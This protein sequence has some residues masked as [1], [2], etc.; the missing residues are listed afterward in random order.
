M[1]EQK[2][3]CQR[4][5]NGSKNNKENTNGNISCKWKNLRKRSEATD[6]SINNNNN[7]KNKKYK[8]KDRESQSS[9]IHTFGVISRMVKE[10][11]KKN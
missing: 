10:N 9:K 1:K 7:N 11:T 5:K 3:S 6:A 2:K 4:P 8:R